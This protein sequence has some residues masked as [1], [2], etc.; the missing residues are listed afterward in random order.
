MFEARRVAVIDPT[1]RYPRAQPDALVAL[2]EQ[3][4]TGIGADAPTLESSG[5]Q[6]TSQGVKLKRLTG[7]LCLQGCFRLVWPKRLIP[8][9]LC[10]W[11][12]PFSTFLVRF[13]G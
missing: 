2:A 12:Q 1:P 11:K 13:S 6:A 5:D 4:A 9:P 8:Q 7:T 3:D 10:H